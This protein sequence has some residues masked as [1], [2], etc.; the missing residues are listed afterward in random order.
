[1]VVGVE[2]GV[3]VTRLRHDEDVTDTSSTLGQQALQFQEMHEGDG[4]AFVMPCAWDAASARLFEHAGFQA[5]GTTSGGVNWSAGRQ[6]YVYAVSRAEMLVAYGAIA[7]ATSLPVSGDLENGYGT[8]AEDVATT[9]SM[10]ID[11]GLAGGSIEDRTS[12]PSPTLIPLDL[13]T[14]RIEA[15]RRAADAVLPGFVLTARAESMYAEIDN[16]ID[17]AIER[18]KHY[19][20]AGAD[21]I[22]V[23]GPADPAMISRLVNEVDAPIS[24]GIGSSGGALDVAALSALGVRRISTGGGIPRALYQS[25][26]DM[27]AELLGPGRFSF[28]DRALPEDTINRLFR[29]PG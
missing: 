11:H 27:S 4:P 7:A 6:D 17:D 12:D 2:R 20:A 10:A 9:V 8:S 19:R 23:P 26:L 1:M 25:V 18:A 3:G 16:P 21:C 14:K 29:P 15:A 5:L 13:A 24:V 22:F 28:T